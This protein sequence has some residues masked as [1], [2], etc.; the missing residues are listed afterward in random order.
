M[1]ESPMSAAYGEGF[2]AANGTDR[3][4]RTDL[5]DLM[6][7]M[8]HTVGIVNFQIVVRP[9]ESVFRDLPILTCRCPAGGEAQRSGVVENQ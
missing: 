6:D 5:M 4:D 3:A 2:A 7:L 8:D 9:A 1:I